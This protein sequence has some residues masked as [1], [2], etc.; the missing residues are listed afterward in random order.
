[1]IWRTLHSTE[2][3]DSILEEQLAYLKQQNGELSNKTR[4]TETN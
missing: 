4:F 2:K 3:V 1:M